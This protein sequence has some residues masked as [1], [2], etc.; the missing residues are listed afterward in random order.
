MNRLFVFGLGYTSQAV[1]RAAMARGFRVA[2]TS[3][4][5]RKCEELKALGIE[6]FEFGEL[7]P[8]ILADFPYILSSIPPQ[9]NGDVV[10]PFLPSASHWLG[11]FSTTGVYGDYDGEWVDELSEP[12][13]NND[14]LKRRLEAEAQWRE[15]GGHVFRLAGIYGKGRSAIDDVQAGKA[16]RIDKA[17]QVF[18]RIHVDD[19]AQTVLA[20]MSCPNPKAIYNVCDDEP[21]AAHEVVSF[22][23]ELL[24]K[25]PL[26]LIPFAQAELS[27]M[28]REFY[29]AN[30]RVKNQFIKQ[31]LGVRLLY[32][33]Y[34]EGLQAIFDEY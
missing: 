8:A 20:S 30:R 11:Y 14:R 17:G 34:R 10:L 5:A 31:E 3:R 12:R 25:E 18:S 26:P 32:P 28:G 4:T 6:A 16:R 21:A 23:C 9:E 24:G 27:P 7:S 1:A 15:R 29:N 2:G 19:I 13:P 22:A 33:S